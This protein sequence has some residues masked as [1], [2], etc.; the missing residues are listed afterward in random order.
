[1]AP[2]SI[3]TLDGEYLRR[4]FVADLRDQYIE[5]GKLPY[6]KLAARS[7]SL[8]RSGGRSMSFSKTTV[9][10]ILN[11][12]A[13]PRWDF[14]VA[15]LRTLDVPE[16]TINEQWRPRW[17]ALMSK[18]HAFEVQPT[19]SDLE[20]PPGTTC[21][22]CGSWVTDPELHKQW[23]A[24]ADSTAAPAS[25]PATSRNLRLIPGMAG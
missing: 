2:T 20:M 3:V 19:E 18:L 16:S 24:G 11:G 10:R 5:S 12:K 1:M 4:Q 21:P 8:P 15:F 17:T 6:R 7:E 22:V 23:H 25:D 9:S 14:V 13:E